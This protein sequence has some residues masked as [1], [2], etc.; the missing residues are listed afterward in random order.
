MSRSARSS[1]YRATV[2]A[3][4][5]SAPFVLAIVALLAVA[6]FA[7]LE[8]HRGDAAALLV[9][10]V[11]ASLDFMR[12]G[13]RIGNAAHLMGSLLSIKPVI[14]VRG[15]VVEQE[16]KQRTRARSLG[17]LVGKPI[18]DAPLERLAVCNG[19]AEDIDV[20]LSQ[21]ENVEVAHALEVVDL[22]PVVGT[23]AGPGP[24]GV[25]YLAASS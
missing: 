2:S 7:N 5:S 24:I 6:L 14:E 3:Y 1:G 8:G 23:P 20:V 11:V 16:S 12:R 17:Y 4:R 10:G 19:A 22:G 13:G 25:G 21:L 15:G 18:A 9:L